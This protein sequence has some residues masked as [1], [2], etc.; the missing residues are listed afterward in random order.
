[1]WKSHDRDRIDRDR[2]GSETIAVIVGTL[3]LLFSLFVWGPWNSSHVVSN[4][5]PS[6]TPRSMAAHQTS[7]SADGTS[8]DKTGMER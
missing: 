1:M 3:V 7:S 4:A 6:G 2:I 5:G 8:G